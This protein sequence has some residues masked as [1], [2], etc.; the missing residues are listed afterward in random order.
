[1]QHYREEAAKGFALADVTAEGVWFFVCESGYPGNIMLH[2]SGSLHFE[3]K[4]KDVWFT[5]LEHLIEAFAFLDAVVGIRT[6]HKFVGMLWHASISFVMTAVD[7]DQ[8]EVVADED[9]WVIRVRSGALVLFQAAD[10]ERTGAS[11]VQYFTNRHADLKW[12]RQQLADY[13]RWGEE[14]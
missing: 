8:K 2:E 5:S 10:L 13:L 11:A 3:T 12:V 1:M 7:A 14:R 6:G 9:I 4:L